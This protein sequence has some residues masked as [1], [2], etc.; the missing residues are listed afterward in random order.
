MLSL[1]VTVFFHSVPSK[2]NDPGTVSGV[3][4]HLKYKANFAVGPEK[5][6]AETVG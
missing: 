4:D 5:V 1:I 6:E 2:K 3:L